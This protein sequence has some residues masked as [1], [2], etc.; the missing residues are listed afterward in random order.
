MSTAVLPEKTRRLFEQSDKL[1][2][3]LNRVFNP[4]AVRPLEKLSGVV[5]P[6]TVMRGASAAL[7]ATQVVVHRIRA[8]R[9]AKGWTQQD[10]EGRSGIARANIARLE[11]GKHAPRVDTVE[12]LA[13]ALSLTLAELFETSA[14]AAKLRELNERRSRAGVTSLRASLQ[15][16]RKKGIVDAN[17]KRVKKELPAEMLEGTSDAV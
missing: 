17:G 8:A 4:D 10:L 6:N 15:A 9:L 16:L 5:R 12:V 2:R 11:A 13:Q 3:K 14:A 1:T 7:S